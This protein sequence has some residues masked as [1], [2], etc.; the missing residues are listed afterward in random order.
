MK[1]YFFFTAM[2]LSSLGLYAQPRSESQALDVAKEFFSQEPA[3]HEVSLKLVPTHDVQS[4][5][6]KISPKTSPSMPSGCYVINDV[7]NN[8]F[9][10]ISADERM[11]EILGYSEEGSFSPDDCPPGLLDMIN[12][13]NQE[14][15]ALISG[16]LGKVA[17]AVEKASSVTVEPLIK[18]KWGQQSPYNN[19]CPK[20]PK[21]TSSRCYTGCV[22]TAM[23]QVMK[24]HGYPEHGEGNTSYSTA[25]YG[26]ELSMDFS[27][28]TFSWSNMPN[29][30]TSS[31]SS[32]QKNAVALLMSACGIA[33]H[34]DYGGKKAGGSSA[35]L[36][37]C[38]YALTNYFNY[39]PNI[40]YLLKQDYN[41]EDWENIIIEDLQNK[42]PV[43][44]GGCKNN[45]G[46]EG[47]AFVLAGYENNKFYVNWGWD[48][49]ANGYF[50]LSSLKPKDKNGTTHNYSYLQDMVCNIGVE[51]FGQPE[52]VFDLGSLTFDYESYRTG[53]HGNATFT[54]FNLTSYKYP[55]GYGKP[56][57]GLVGIG[58]FD[59]DFNYIQ[60]LRGYIFEKE[61]VDDYNLYSYYGYSELP[62]E[63]FNFTKST[64]KE[65][66]EFYFAPFYKLA[67]SDQYVCIPT[68]GSETDYY[69]AS[70]K[71]GSVYLKKMGRPEPLI[72]E[73]DIIANYKMGNKDIEPDHCVTLMP[74][75]EEPFKYWLK[76]LI[77]IDDTDVH[78]DVTE[79]DPSIFGM[80]KKAEYEETLIYGYLETN[81]N[82]RIPNNQC[83][84]SKSF[85]DYYIKNLSS[86]DEII[87]TV[88]RT[89]STMTIDKKWG[90]IINSTLAE[91]SS[92]EYMSCDY[93]NFKYH[94]DVPTKLTNIAT[95]PMPSR[96]VENV[97][98][99]N[100]QK[101][102]KPQKGIYIINGKK[103]VV[104]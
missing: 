87:V 94:V 88:N 33:V 55:A 4:G 76:N 92:Y 71:D 25:K 51:E 20:D 21:D 52:P 46:D 74:D 36:Y 22:A 100:G 63:N 18:T 73:Y 96:I 58:V 72:G 34:M 89:E 9:V 14:Y 79:P 26:I 97:Y 44:Y 42:R 66:S 93:A 101:V 1:K 104:K 27:S 40:R 78:E 12:C 91:D 77:I 65:G 84:F 28:T 90:V 10:I 23:A 85:N 11:Y 53:S 60:S 54:D 16:K 29:K 64:F 61:E 32:T 50:K 59:L 70:V 41:D 99:L 19:K 81:G 31:S 49:T 37:N 98:N 56:F 30:C 48:G 5:I 69:F 95:D 62:F 102:E 35:I 17:R 8:R 82:L 2:L 80:P 39:N 68:S 45:D 57:E 75:E 67:D 24:Y 15:D 7:A 83:F 6:R 13:Y 47:H 103:V 3:V 43:I 86:D 38:A